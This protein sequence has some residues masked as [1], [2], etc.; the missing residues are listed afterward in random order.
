ME[1]V[2]HVASTGAVLVLSCWYVSLLL[3]TVLI[4]ARPVARMNEMMHPLL[5]LQV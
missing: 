5:S 3:A 2:D 4:W 1:V